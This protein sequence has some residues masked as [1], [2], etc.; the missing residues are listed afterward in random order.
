VL[1]DFL[2]LLSPLYPLNRDTIPFVP[3][4]HLNRLNSFIVFKSAFPS[5]AA[6]LAFAFTSFAAAT[7]TARAQLAYVVDAAGLLSSFDVTTPGTRTSIGSLGF[8]VSGIDFRPGTS[9][10]YAFRSNNVGSPGTAGIYTVNTATGAATL[11]GSGFATSLLGGSTTFGFDFNP[12][13]LQGDGSLRIRLTGDTGLNLR[14]NSDTGLI[15]DTD[16]ALSGTITSANAVAYTR[17]DFASAGGATT[18]YYI[19]PTTDTL[20]T[21]SAPNGGVT[22]SVGSLGFDF[23][24]N[25]NFDIFTAGS[26]HTGYASNG[27]DFYSINLSTGAAT[28]IATNTANFRSGIA[29]FTSPIPEPSTYAALAGVAVLGLAVTARRRRA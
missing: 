26:T 9:T 1:K 20:N 15:S 8:S 13:T 19:D 18:L 21:S 6:R 3:A 5:T 23:I 17:T 24:G 7:F 27:N 14:L 28:F 11:V 29:V 25:T 22:T 2:L 16:T 12:T 10:L 4:R